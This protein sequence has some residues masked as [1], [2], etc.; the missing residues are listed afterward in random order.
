[1]YIAAG[2]GGP[3]LPGKF[4]RLELKAA[5]AQLLGIENRG[6]KVQYFGI[7]RLAVDDGRNRVLY[8]LG[9]KGEIGIHTIPF[10][11]LKLRIII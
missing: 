9:R 4:K 8:L 1:M 2:F 11:G 5:F 10:S 7:N 3:Q 6:V